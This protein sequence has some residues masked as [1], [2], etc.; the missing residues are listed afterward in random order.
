MAEQVYLDRNGVRI[1]SARAI[2]GNKT[3]VLAT[4]TSVEGRRRNPE[5]SV[6]YYVIL[7]GVLACA[8]SASLFMDSNLRGVVSLSIGV[9][10][11]ASGAVWASR[12]G[13]IYSVILCTAAGEQRVFAGASESEMSEIVAALNQ[14]II[15]RGHQQPAG[16]DPVMDS[17]DPTNSSE[18]TTINPITSPY[19]IGI[20]CVSM[21]VIWAVIIFTRG[22]DGGGDRP[23]APGKGETGTPYNI[24][25]DCYKLFSPGM[26]THPLRKRQGC[27]PRA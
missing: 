12:I 3:Y 7:G 16:E 24:A 26:L 15:D 18:A 2:F 11:I 27:Y 4:I 25:S 8:L 13:P 14:A 17:P 5:R 22:G 10:L 20:G 19:T 6:P 23:K 9:I 21:L 1:T